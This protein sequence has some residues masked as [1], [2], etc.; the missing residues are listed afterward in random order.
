MIGKHNAFLAISKVY[1]SLMRPLSSLLGDFRK[2]CGFVIA[3]IC[4]GALM[5]ILLRPQHILVFSWLH[6]ASLSELVISLRQSVCGLALPK[7]MLYSLPD[8]LWVFA[9]TSS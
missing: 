1:K 4:I 3:P 2:W 5:Y 7:W 8:G 9:L 6:A